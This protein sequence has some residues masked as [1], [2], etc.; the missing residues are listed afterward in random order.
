MSLGF[1]GIDCHHRHAPGSVIGEERVHAIFTSD[2]E[3]T[4]IAGKDDHEDFRVAEV[5]QR[6]VFSIDRRKIDQLSR[7]ISYIQD[8][9]SEVIASLITAERFTASADYTAKGPYVRLRYKFDESILPQTEGPK[10]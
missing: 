5:F 6:I 1:I 9:P 2:H 4:V 8:V 10:K 7:G 3:R